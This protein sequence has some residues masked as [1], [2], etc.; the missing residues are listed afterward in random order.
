MTERLGYTP[1]R[2]P[3]SLRRSRLRAEGYA[4]GQ[5]GRPKAS[6]EAEYLTSYR[7]GREAKEAK[8]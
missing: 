7:R 2:V 1:T 4:D 5:A 6:T 3:E 8:K